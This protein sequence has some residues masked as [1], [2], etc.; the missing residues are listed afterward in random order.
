MIEFV[1]FLL[2][3]AA[4]SGWYT[5][6]RRYKS[7]PSSPK[8]ETKSGYFKGIN[9]LLNEQPEKAIDV[10]V[11]MLEVDHE[12]I[13]T[14][15]A[16]GS[17]FR[18][19]GEVEKAI[20]LHQNLIARPQLEHGVRLDV[21]QE[22]GL[23]YMRAGLFDRAEALFTE[24]ENHKSHEQT[25]V[26][27]LL[28]IYQQEREWDQAIEYAKKLAAI[29]KTQNPRLLSHLFCESAVKHMKHKDLQGADIALKKALSA[30]SNCFR[31]N[32]L[33]ADLALDEKN[34]KLALKHLLAIE[35]QS[36]GFLSEVL[37]KI[38]QCFDELD[39]SKE[40]FVYLKHLKSDLKMQVATPYLLE[41]IREQE[42]DS[43]AVEFM[44]DCLQ[45]MPQITDVAAYLE[46]CR[47]LNQAPDLSFLTQVLQQLIPVEREYQ[48]RKCGHLSKD[49]HWQCTRCQKWGCVEPADN[50][51]DLAESTSFSI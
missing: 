46:L 51:N 13:E 35:D 31:V 9:Y 40:K 22:L 28:D 10:F 14:H 3:I 17:L 11:D 44:I 23:D 2:P 6:A 8:T 32:L 43:A 30:D 15:L 47:A 37:P 24:L 39:Q 42:G 38:L 4:A 34:F 33:K 5:A 26:S 49:M 45:E 18:R 20:R 7:R 27:R 50:H 25:A 16:L 19:R 29:M 1:V 36:T 48:C 41:M 12:I 21:L